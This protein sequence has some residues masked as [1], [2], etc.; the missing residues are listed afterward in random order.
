MRAKPGEKPK[1]ARSPWP[2]RLF[3]FGVTASAA[4]VVGGCVWI[5][6][7]V[8]WRGMGELSVG[9][10]VES[11]RDAGR[12]GGIAPILVSTILLLGVALASA[13]P[14]ALGA[15]ISLAFSPDTRVVRALR[16]LLDVLAA[17]PSI[18]FGLFGNALFCVALGLRFSI[19]AGG[20]TLACMILPFVTRTMEQALRAV[21]LEQRLA[22]AS[23]GMSRL[24]ILRR[25]ILPS[26]LPGMM[27]GV[28]LGIG[29]A[30]SETAALLFTAGYSVRFPR[31]WSDSGRNLS[32]HLYDLA[33]NVPGGNARAYATGF[34]LVA[35]LL[36]I[37]AGALLLVKRL[38]FT[39]P[40]EQVLL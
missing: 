28:V 24:A 9:F 11:P 38:S 3:S 8:V 23:L 12:A 1:T 40:S 7:D 13:I 34:V 36:I 6:G 20:L 21:P 30:F 19:L 15:A 37:N 33:M 4:V 18:I 32:V 27:A 17:V 39:P 5:V 26:A 31:G 14:V 29:R 25:V 2:D 22:A 10:L 16:R 35:V